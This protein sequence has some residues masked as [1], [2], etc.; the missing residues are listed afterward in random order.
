MIELCSLQITVTLILHFLSRIMKFI[1]CLALLASLHCYN[2]VRQPVVNKENGFAVIELFTS[3]GCSSCPPA[4]RLVEQVSRDYADKN[5]LVL[6]YHVDYW[7][8]LGW[9]DRFSSAANTERQNIYAEIFH[10]N[11]VYTPQAVINGATEFTG[12]DKARMNDALQDL[13]APQTFSISARAEEEKINVSVSDIQLRSDEEL[14][15][16]LVEKQDS[17]KV[18][19][20]E[21]EGR[22]LH[23]I[24]IVRNYTILPQNTFSTVFQLNEKQ[25]DNY[26]LAALLQKKSS[27]EILGY[28]KTPIK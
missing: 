12:S 1:F 20:G 3:E 25:S 28:A 13:K 14:V 22:S 26:F 17:T 7:D 18:R 27:G 2:A 6:S 16:A 21:N 10:L 19:S 23:H 5:V 9:K 4:D 11:S 8:G 15:I 24:N